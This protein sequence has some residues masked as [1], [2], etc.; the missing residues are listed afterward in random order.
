MAIRLLS[1]ENIDGN[2]TFAGT[3]AVGGATPTTNAIEIN[4]ADGTS[5]VFFKSAVATTGARVGLNGDD[6]RVFNQQ[7]A[8]EL[9]LGTNGATKLTIDSSGNSTFAGTTKQT[10]IEIESTSPQILFDETDVT[11]NWRNRVQGGSWRV[12]YASN[13]SNFS[14]YFIVGANNASFVTSV[15]I[16]TTS[17]STAL[18]IDQPSNDRA[19]GLYLELNGHNYGLSAFVNSGGY[20]VIG[21]NGDYTT[22]IF[23]NGFKFR[24]CRNWSNF[25]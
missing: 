6:L 8:G 9:H 13:G 7:A 10:G 2:A 14:N 19:G 16:G 20:G 4:G 5:Y 12:Q 25:I 1:S 17:P 3:I 22:D 11:A 15:G 23:N 21:S 24:K 18:H